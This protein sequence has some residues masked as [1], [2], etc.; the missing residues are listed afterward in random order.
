MV[1]SYSNKWF[2]KPGVRAHIY[3]R[4]NVEMQS[5][6]GGGRGLALFSTDDMVI[7]PHGVDL[8][9]SKVYANP[10]MLDFQ[11]SWLINHLLFL[12]SPHT[13]VNVI[14]TKPE[15]KGMWLLKQYS[16]F[17]LVYVGTCVP[18]VSFS[19]LALHRCPFNKCNEMDTSFKKC[20]P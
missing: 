4:R 5:G 18:Y 8:L 14:Y 6:G 9:T 10:H 11:Y 7:V 2:Y 16:F 17:T 12:A 13:Y 3:V 19:S 15:P 20:K 1:L